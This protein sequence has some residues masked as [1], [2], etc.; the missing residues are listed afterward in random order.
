MT[1]IQP[2]I[3]KVQPLLARHFSTVTKTSNNTNIIKRSVLISQSND[4]FTNLAL[5]DWFYRNYDFTN[6]H[7]MMLWR[8]NPCIVIGRHQN[9]W[10]EANTTNLGHIAE[11]GVQLARRNSGGGTV[12]HDRGNLNVTFF[13]GRKEY[14]RRHNLEL[15]TRAIFKEYGIKIDISP[16][17]DLCINNIKVSGTAAKLGQPSAYHHCTLLVN[18]DKANLSRALQK[19]EYEIKTNA[20]KSVKSQIVNLCELNPRITIDDLLY[21]IG[22]EYMNPQNS[23]QIINPT[24]QQFPGITEIRDTLRDWEWCYGKTPK[25]SVTKSFIGNFNSISKNLK[26]TINIEQ[27]RI[28]DMILYVPSGEEKVITSLKGQKFTEDII[29]CLE[30]PLSGEENNLVDDKDRLVIECIRKVMI[31]V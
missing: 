8:N 11:N 27:G 3:T 5:E 12:Y 1:F 13:T 14:N 4:I 25:F 20:T 9:P 23:F 24:E 7:I 31:S 19:R 21:V 22:R 29:N 10:L 6:H 28:N 18:V 26:F 2:T 16:R 30:C 17:E 15:I